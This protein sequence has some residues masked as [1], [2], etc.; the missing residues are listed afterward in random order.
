MIRCVI[1]DIDGTM[2]DYERC[3]PLAME[4]V[5]KYCAEHVGLDG[6]AFAAAH[7]KAY[8]EAEA[9][10]GG[11]CAAVHN[12]LL[13]YQWILEEAGAPLFPHAL[14]MYHAYWD[15]MLREMTAFDGL[16][17]WMAAL[18]AS[19]IRIGAGSN[20][21]AYMQYKK[22]ERLQLG[23]YLDFLVTSE[24]TG[25]EKPEQRFFERCLEK[26]GFPAEECLFVGDSLK[27]DVMGALEAG[28][29]ALLYH[30][31][32]DVACVPRDPSFRVIHAY[33]ECMSPGFDISGELWY[34]SSKSR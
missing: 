23:A 4:E 33:A 29:H 1:F 11:R 7:K 27:G 18:R 14:N 32:S 9:R 3:N 12:R 22:L 8:R 5:R 28:M 2:Y 20:M 25:C 13:R 16:A 31:G 24:E 30:P 26:S 19:G 34:G 21:T 15:T 17:E 10:I 6:E